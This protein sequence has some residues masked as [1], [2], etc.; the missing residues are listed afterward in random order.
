MFSSIVESFIN[1]LCGRYLKNFTS[2]NVSVSVTGTITLTDVEI[3]LDELQEFSLPHRPIRAY[4]G[5]LRID[6]P[7]V[8]G[9]NF[10]ILVKDAFFLMYRGDD[11]EDSSYDD[12]I[13]SFLN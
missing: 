13:H 9:G 12:V 2:E 7:I 11:S 6:I 1:R 4:I 5:S 10:D 8:L 3:K